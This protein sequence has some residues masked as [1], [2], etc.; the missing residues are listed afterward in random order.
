MI[1]RI[2]ATAL[3]GALLASS[4][5][6][7]ARQGDQWLVER[8]DSL[9]RIA[10][11]LAPGDG[12]RQRQLVR[13]F[14]AVNPAAFKDGDPNKLAAG[15]ALDIPNDEQ[16]GAAPAGPTTA[17]T[18]AG[19]AFAERKPAAGKP[20]PPRPADSK[21][22][23]ATAAAPAAQ[24]AQVDGTAGRV[25][26]SRGTATAA[27]AGGEVRGL[28]VDSDVYEGDTIST[29]PGSYVRLKYSDGATMLL[30]PSTRLQVA[31][32]D[33]TGDP[34]TDGALLNLVKGG[35]RTVT[36]AIGRENRDAYQ[37]NTPIATIGIRGTDYTVLLCQGCAGVDDGLYMTVDLGGTTLTAGGQTSNFDVG[38]NAFLPIS[39]G[40]P[41]YIKVAPEAL[42]LPDP[43]CE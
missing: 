5:A 9:S 37:V 33:N 15:V 8:G 42:H 24:P 14:V 3:F 38:E 26:Y 17:P 28:Q 43:G 36:G 27:T 30:R 13:A 6:F 1:K 35:F 40:A 22:A 7:A 39:G 4:A 16:I 12:A 41:Q 21:G 11:A 34:Q 10:A 18:A 20:A 23:T 2:F 32:Y 25:V 29:D 19:T 31:K